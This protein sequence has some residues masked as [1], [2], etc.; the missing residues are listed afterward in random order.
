MAN[1]VEALTGGVAAVA[2][3]GAAAAALE[4]V[5]EPV[6]QDAWK[7]KPTRILDE[8]QLA[9]LVA[10]AL[11]TVAD[12]IDDVNRNGLDADEFQSL[13]QLA[14][15]SPGVPDAEKLYL[16]SHGNYPGAITLA[17]LHHAYGKAGIEHQWWDPLTAA[18]GSVL[19][20]PAQL[21]LGAVRG[22]LDDQDLLV[23]PLDT[24]GSNIKQYTPAAL[25]IIDEAAAQG[26]NTERLRA[27]IGSIGLPLGSIAAAQANFRGILTD[28]AYYQAILE[29]DTRPEWADAIRDYARQIPSTHEFVE[30]RLRGYYD[31][32]AEMYAQTARH[33][34]SQADTD[35][36]FLNAGRPLNI[37]QVTTGLARGGVY[38]GPTDEIPDVF[39]DAVR[40]SNIKPPYY[41][42][43]FA[44]RYTY[45]TGFMIKAEAVAG[46]LQPEDTQ[47][48]LLE[49]GW[50]PKWAA[51]F[52]EK[53][54]GRAPGAGAAAPT[55][56]AVV[57]SHVGSAIT[58]IRKAYVGVQLSEANARANLA[59]LAVPQTDID[60]LIK[61]WNVQRLATLPA[62][63][64]TQIQ[65]GFIT[66]P[67]AVTALQHQGYSADEIAE[68]LGPAPA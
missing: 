51:F 68:L 52:T 31:T 60:S 21:A 50:S 15:K 5:F 67:E 46:T 23:L 66:Y 61:V 1:V 22:T 59:A 43:D 14:L 20:T 16:R 3:G 56:S 39:L 27:L 9:T 38:N 37:H 65:K 4:P 26:V 40:E 28:G 49:I 13:V 6:K 24:S 32:D 19:L 25:N 30:H 45:P 54:T 11:N 47:E 35:V 34:M 8:N 55:Q 64:V 29:G 2:V 18:A 53:W 62:L 33:G 12:V 57:K 63:T 58:A 42:L 44:N 7:K 48:I 10:Q 36:Q 41:N 17:Q